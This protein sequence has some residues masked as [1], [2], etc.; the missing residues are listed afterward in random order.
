MVQIIAQCLIQK[1]E[2]ALTYIW[3]EKMRRP[4]NKAII[5]KMFYIY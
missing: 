5:I 3:H 2:N 1:R 4:K